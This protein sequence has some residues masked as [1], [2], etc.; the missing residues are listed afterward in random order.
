[1][2]LQQ[3]C[4]N[5]RLQC[6]MTSMTR[7]YC[8]LDEGPLSV[9]RCINSNQGVCSN[10]SLFHRSLLP[11]GSWGNPIW[12]NHKLNPQITKPQKDSVEKHRM[13]E[14][15]PNKERRDPVYYTNVSKEEEEEGVWGTL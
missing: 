9:P 2:L 15:V 12:T 4:K 3:L 13:Q 8:I 10:K 1:M 7:I 5:V 11:I 14:R 6:K